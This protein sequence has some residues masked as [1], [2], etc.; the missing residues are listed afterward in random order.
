MTT[1]TTT[2]PR[3]LSVIIADLT[4]KLADPTF[5]DVAQM[6][7]DHIAVL[8][9][10][11]T[12]ERINYIAD[13]LVEGCGTPEKVTFEGFAADVYDTIAAAQKAR[14]DYQYRTRGSRS[15]YLGEST[16]KCSR[17][18]AAVLAQD[19]VESNQCLVFLNIL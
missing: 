5:G 12:E 4:A 16:W 14:Q 2:A 10:A 6:D 11:T 3:K 19:I 13:L 8:R 7:L 9:N 17:K 15:S 18:Q 1:A